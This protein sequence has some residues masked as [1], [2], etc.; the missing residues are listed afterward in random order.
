MAVIDGQRKFAGF[1]SK[2]GNYPP[3][4]IDRGP[5]APADR[6]SVCGCRTGRY[7]LAHE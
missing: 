3:G 1:Q 2:R 7:H 4:G 6:D 5:C